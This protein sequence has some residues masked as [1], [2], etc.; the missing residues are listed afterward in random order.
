[1][2]HNFIYLP[3]SEKLMYF[4]SRKSNFDIKNL[5]SDQNTQFFDVVILKNFK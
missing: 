2:P 4:D 1:M 3:I 5:C